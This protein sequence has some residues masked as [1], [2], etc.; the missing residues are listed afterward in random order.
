MGLCPTRFFLK[1]SRLT[2]WTTELLPQRSVVMHG[3]EGVPFA[4]GWDG[5]AWDA[6][7]PKASTRLDL[8]PQ[9]GPRK[10]S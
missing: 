7:Q 2:T 4:L 9:D 10:A 3:Q 8:P 6:D 1:V 5:M